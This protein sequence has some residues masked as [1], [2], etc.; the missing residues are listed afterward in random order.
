M[1]DTM[2]IEQI[3]DDFMK[4]LRQI[5]GKDIPEPVAVWTS[6]WGCVHSSCSKFLTYFLR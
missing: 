3:R 6:R 4:V 2:P 5:F 1:Q